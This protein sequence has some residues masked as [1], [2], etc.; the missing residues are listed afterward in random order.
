MFKNKVCKLLVI[1]LVSIVMCMSFVACAQGEKGEQ[2]IQGE[3]GAQGE[4]GLQ[5]EKGEKGEQGLQGIPGVKGEKGEQGLQGIQGVQGETGV[6]VVSVKVNYV[7]GKCVFIFTMSDGSTISCTVPTLAN[8]TDEL[9]NVIQNAEI[10]EEISLSAS[11]YTLPNGIVEGIKIVGDGTTKINLEQQEGPYNRINTSNTTFEG[12]VFEQSVCLTG[13]A[14]FVNCVFKKGTDTC[15][16]TGDI[17]FIGCTFESDGAGD[18]AMHI[19]G[20]D[21]V[22]K[23]M[24][25]DCDFTAGAVAFNGVAEASFIGCDFSGAFSWKYMRAYAPTLLKNCTFEQGLTVKSAGNGIGN[26]TLQNTNVTVE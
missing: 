10:G 16:A 24:F 1:M 23:L 25:E 17:T 12:L 13:S 9:K 2:G 4:Q 18:F 15:T 20:G 6:G 5:G 22:S 26:I 14:T 21:G 3:Q 8:D 11:E 19:D 7:N